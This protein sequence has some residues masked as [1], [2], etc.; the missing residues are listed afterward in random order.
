MTRPLPLAACLFLL[1]LPAGAQAPAKPARATLVILVP[2][3]ATITIDGDLT[4]QTG[5]TRHF[6]TPTLEPGKRYKYKVVMELKPNNYVTRTRTRTAYVY[7]GKETELDLRKED[8]KNKDNIVIRYVPTPQFVVDAMCKLGKVGKDD[9]VYD[10]GCGDGR[11]VITAVKKFNARRGV[12]IDL[13][14]KRLDEC[15]ENAEE[16]KVTDKVSFR[17]EN[18][19]KLTDLANASV[20]TLYM[21]DDLNE[22]VRPL[23]WKQCKPGTRIVT[24][25]FL[26][27]DWKPEK[28]EPLKDDD[29][30]EFLVH[31]WTITG[32][33][34]EG[35][36]A[37]Q[38][39][40]EED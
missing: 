35:K 4:R 15:K 21:S 11:I 18:V 27:G 16:A 24:H 13:D 1:V 10:L 30:E 28:T 22:A 3:D 9:V 12:G 23:L 8:P 36:Y 14:Q 37:K 34:Q 20:V 39:K 26:M 17:K 2:E 6:Y 19:L 25:R 5:T 33:E 32:K 38:E 7:A 31:L 29:G 40:K